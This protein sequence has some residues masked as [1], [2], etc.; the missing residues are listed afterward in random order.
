[1]LVVVF[2]RVEAITTRDP[3]A[4]KPLRSMPV[5]GV[6]VM[7][8]VASPVSIGTDASQ[9]AVAVRSS[10]SACDAAFGVV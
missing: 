4:T 8:S 9:V 10:S 6:C 2:V 3:G 1:M 7:V 5:I